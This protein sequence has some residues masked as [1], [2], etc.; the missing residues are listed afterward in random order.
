M[1]VR[2]A[3]RCTF[4][5]A[6]FFLVEQSFSYL[7]TSTGSTTLF[8]AGRL[9]EIDPAE[10]DPGHA[11][12]QAGTYGPADLG[13]HNR[14][15]LPQSTN[16]KDFFVTVKKNCDDND[17]DADR[18]PR[19]QYCVRLTE[20][21]ANPVAFVLSLL[22]GSNSTEWLAD[23]EQ[24]NHLNQAFNAI[25]KSSMLSALHALG[26]SLRKFLCAS[27]K[28]ESMLGDA[29]VKV[30]ANPMMSYAPLIGLMQFIRF[31]EG[32]NVFVEASECVN[33]FDREHFYKAPYNQA[34]PKRVP[35][36]DVQARSI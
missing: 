6:N 13:G 24:I 5:L 21:G 28:Q 17:P 23:Q 31:C 18:V 32:G 12:V 2:V 9:F 15:A 19:S 30:F 29:F 27:D 22:K 35:L 20:V 34:P 26:R 10:E 16:S 36:L 3:F 33:Y 4:L 8:S 14:P 1:F 25:M 11:I 7:V